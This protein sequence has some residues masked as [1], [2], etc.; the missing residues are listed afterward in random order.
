[1]KHVFLTIVIHRILRGIRNGR[2]SSNSSCE[3]NTFK[4]STFFTP[5]TSQYL[6]SAVECSV[7][8]RWPVAMMSE[9]TDLPDVSGKSIFDLPGST[10]HC[11]LIVK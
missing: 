9:E 2:L 4:F 1:M 10:L 3:K 11:A 6:L 7:S 5:F 8:G